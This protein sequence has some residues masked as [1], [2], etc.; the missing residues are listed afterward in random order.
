[1]REEKKAATR[2]ALVDEAVRRF[3]TDGYEATPLEQIAAAVPVSMR[4]LLRYFE[5][6]ERLFHAWHHVALDRF[7][8]QL[9]AR[10]RETTV[11]AFWRAWV[12]KY[13]TLAVESAD[14]VRHRQMQD[15]VPSLQAHWLMIL[16]EYEDLLAAALEAEVDTPTD[17]RLA[18]VAMVSGNEAVTRAWFARGATGDLVHDSLRVIDRI[19]AIF[20]PVGVAF[21]PPRKARR[22]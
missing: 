3:L 21:E 5:S 15:A 16:Q 11:L 8:S 6:K 2:R 19:A 9:A 4:T 14:L 18:A 17:A 1:L 20:G 10:P 7:R 22:A 13:A 12:A